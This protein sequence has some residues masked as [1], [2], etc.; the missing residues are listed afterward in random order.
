MKFKRN[1]VF[2]FHYGKLLGQLFLCVPLFR[3]MHVGAGWFVPQT[4]EEALAEE[5]SGCG[6]RGP[7]QEQ[8]PP[9]SPGL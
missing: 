2:L 1:F 5:A 8:T 9:G 6:K 3:T 7:S 4:E